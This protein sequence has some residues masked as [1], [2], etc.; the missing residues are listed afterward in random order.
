MDMA[1][2]K[3]VDGPRRSAFVEGAARLDAIARPGAQNGEVTEA[4]DRMSAVSPDE[5]WNRRFM[6]MGIGPDVP[7]R[8][9]PVPRPSLAPQPELAPPEPLVARGAARVQK[10][11]A[12]G[13]AI[14]KPARRSLLTRLFRG[15]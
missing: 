5:V 3:L 4:R 11:G 1:T 15:R 2:N 12:I 10:G 7:L 13:A 14:G 8:A 6:S 9:P